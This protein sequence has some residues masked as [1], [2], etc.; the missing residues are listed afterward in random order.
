M[1]RKDLSENLVEELLSILR[2][3]RFLEIFEKA[4][5]Y[6]GSCKSGHIIFR[7][8]PKKDFLYSSDSLYINFADFYRNKLH[9][10]VVVDE[11]PGDAEKN[12]LPTIEGLLISC[13]KNRIFFHI[14]INKDILD[15]SAWL[16]S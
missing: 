4:N 8:V 6:S 10:D 13:G 5:K 3:E 14:E 9:C 11:F 15:L 12:I 16:R 2:E 1:S 7:I